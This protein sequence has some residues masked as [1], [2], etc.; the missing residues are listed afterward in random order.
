[1]L[2]ISHSVCLFV[3]LEMYMTSPASRLVTREVCYHTC[4]RARALAML[5]TQEYSRSI[6]CRS[7]RR[8]IQGVF[9]EYSNR[10]DSLHQDGDIPVKGVAFIADVTA[11]LKAAKL[12]PANSRRYG[13]SGGHTCTKKREMKG[14]HA[15]TQ[16]TFRQTGKQI[17]VAHRIQLGVRLQCCNQ[18]QC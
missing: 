7:I 8:S 6:Q 10:G 18:T 1:M 15:H 13:D 9:K 4:E 5:P 12:T 2:V 14:A 3:Q 17:L 11:S 16:R